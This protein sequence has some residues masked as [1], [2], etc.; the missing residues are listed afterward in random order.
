MIEC[1]GI[2]KFYEV[3]NKRV[4]A[5]D[6]INLS[7]NSGEFVAITGSSGSGKSTLMNILGCLDL[8]SGGEYFINRKNVFKLGSGALSKLRSR[9]IGF[10]FQSFNLLPDLTAL[11]NVCLPMLYREVSTKK[12]VERALEALKSVNM[13]ERISH[14]PSQLSGGQ[15]QR[16]SI[17]RAIIGQPKLILADEPTG[18]LDPQNAREVLAL[19]KK[20]SR[21]G[22]TVVMVTHDMQIAQAADRIVRLSHGKIDAADYM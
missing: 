8:A 15:Q 2:S 5:L 3:E 16:V 19:L 22:K 7:L 21:E 9:D 20:Q 13:E 4:T 1:I 6:N 12:S 18:N 10:I 11:E 17:A 14:L